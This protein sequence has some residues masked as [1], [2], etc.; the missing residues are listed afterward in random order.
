MTKEKIFIISGELSGET[1]IARVAYE[2]FKIK[3]GIEIRAMG[4]EILKE[5]GAEIVIDYRNYNFSG[6]TEVLLNIV[7]IIRLR[8]KIV[9]EIIDFEPNVLVLVDYAGFNLEVAKNLREKFLAKK[10]TKHA[11]KKPK[12]IEF[13]A[14]QLW[15]TRPYRI[16]TIKKNI[17]KVLCTLPFEEA[18]YKKAGIPVRYVGNPVSSSLSKAISKSEL[19]SELNKIARYPKSMESNFKKAEILIGVFPGSRNFE[20]KY[21]LPEYIKAIEELQSL[22]LKPEHPYSYKFVLVRAITIRPGLLRKCGLTRK[23][24]SELVQVISSKELPNA[25]HK[26]LS[27]ADFL[28]LCSGTVTLEAAL[29]GTPYFLS[30]RG[31]WINYQ[32]YKALKIIDMAGL[33]NIIAGKYIVKEFLQKKAISSNFIRETLKCL[34]LKKDSEELFSDYYYK[35]IREFN[36][37]RDVLSDKDTPKLVAEEIMNLQCQD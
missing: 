2:L 7:K 12:I 8:N 29:Y 36:I 27:G 13:I 1:H 28:W 16:R 4:S 17:D 15:A 5:I 32:I 25:N 6:L 34:N 21:L 14:P 20:I 26:V 9:K 23:L 3:P 37:L 31:N 30:Y 35:I 10:N 33:A 11:F 22:S 19:L 18:I 24:E